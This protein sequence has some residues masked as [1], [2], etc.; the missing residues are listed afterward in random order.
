[1]SPSEIDPLSPQDSSSSGP[2]PEPAS[3]AAP[4]AREYPEDIRTPWDWTELLIFAVVGLASYIILSTILVLAFYS[5]GISFSDLQNSA[6]LRSLFAV[7]D[8]L[9]LWL[10][11][12]GYLSFTIRVRFH[13][14]VWQTLGWRPFSGK[15]SRGLAIAGCLAGGGVFAIFIGIASNFVGKKAKLPI[16]A[17]FQ[18][19]R[20]I[21]MMMLM[22]VV[23]AP[24]VEETLFRGYLYPLFARTFGIGGGVLLTGLLFGGFHAMQL[25]GGWGQI[26]LLILV[27][28]VFT[29][30]RAVSQTVL[31]SYLLHV[32]YNTFLFVTFFVSTSGF[33]KLPVTH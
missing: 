3:L 17:F 31:A 21:W 1:M 11:L 29:Y 6:I 22:A 20:S 26:A 25:W 18:D 23:V 7:L 15:I 8:T 10:V 28:V 2:A 32:S 16:E 14:P 27:G 30:V 9:L 13:A 24:F 33:H 5:R 12:L 4:P 19:R